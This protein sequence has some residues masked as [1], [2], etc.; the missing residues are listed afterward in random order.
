MTLYQGFV[1]Y[2]GTVLIYQIKSNSNYKLAVS[3]EGGLIRTSKEKL[4]MPIEDLEL[5]V[6][7]LWIEPKDKQILDTEY[8]R[9]RE[10]LGKEWLERVECKAMY[11]DAKVELEGKSYD[12]KTKLR[13]DNLVHYIGDRS[14]RIKLS[15]DQTILGMGPSFNLRKNEFISVF[16]HILGYKL[17]ELLG[18]PSPS[19]TFVH[20]FLNGKY[21]GLRTMFE[22]YDEG[23]IEHHDYDGW[24]FRESV[25]APQEMLYAYHGEGENDYPMWNMT[26]KTAPKN[27][28]WSMFIDTL[29]LITE[30]DDETFKEKIVQFIDV[31]LLIRFAGVATLANG[32]YLH[33]HDNAW[34]IEKEKK[35][36]LPVVNDLKGFA[37]EPEKQLDPHDIYNPLFWRLFSLST[38]LYAEKDHVLADLIEKEIPLEEMHELIDGI[39]AGVRHDVEF[40]N[41]DFEQNVIQTKEMITRR[42]EFLKQH[43][44]EE[45][46][47]LVRVDDQIV[48]KFTPT[49]SWTIEGILVFSGAEGQIFYPLSHTFYPEWI[50]FRP[51]IFDSPEDMPKM[52][53]IMEY[54]EQLRA[55]TIS[56]P[57]TV[58]SGETKKLLEGEVWARNASGELVKSGFSI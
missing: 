1:R 16:P 29:N 54:R 58:L 40:G 15:G 12:A 35:K 31:P 6:I 52:E 24:L 13:G 28:G 44:Y 50:G 8:I 14:Y 20:L 21:R 48:L 23:F 46:P 27:E 38:G 36:M 3:Q 22:N 4:R 10:C 9:R 30:S 33:S 7:S 26:G 32:W 25:Q 18:L 47:H 53:S 11:V 17:G 56:F 49:E 37:V 2:Y 34:L 19:S 5:P 45:Q 39:L 42:Y 55:K 43:L 57:V 41:N 51:D